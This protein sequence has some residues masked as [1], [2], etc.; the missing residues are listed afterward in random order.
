MPEGFQESN[1][2][3]QFLTI[4]VTYIFLYSIECNFSLNNFSIII[5]YIESRMDKIFIYKYRIGRWCVPKILAALPL[6]CNINFVE[7]TKFKV[8]LTAIWVTWMC[9]KQTMWH[10]ERSKIHW[11]SIINSTTHLLRIVPAFCLQVVRYW[12]GNS[13]ALSLLCL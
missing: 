13:P 1:F 2:Y 11:Q 12:F 3:S 4:K 9:T 10:L 5:F 7:D 8:I 6:C